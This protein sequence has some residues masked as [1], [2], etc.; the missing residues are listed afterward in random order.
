V[1]GDAG[2]DYAVRASTNL[3]NWETIFSTNSPA[4]PFNWSDTNANLYPFRFYQVI[5]GP[6]LP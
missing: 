4:M 3:L 6:P 1:S 2:P 5:L